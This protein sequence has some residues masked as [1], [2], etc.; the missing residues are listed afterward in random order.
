MH[1]YNTENITPINSLLRNLTKVQTVKTQREND[2]PKLV[3][4]NLVMSASITT[5]K[6]EQVSD[7]HH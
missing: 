2:I 4:K 6:T 7:E 5:D 1:I 3:L